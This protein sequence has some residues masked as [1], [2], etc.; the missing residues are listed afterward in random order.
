MLGLLGALDPYKYKQIQ[1]D[2]RANQLQV[3]SDPSGGTAE[4]PDSG[5]LRLELVLHDVGS[6]IMV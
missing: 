6:L 2:A 5:M 4:N 1:M 3:T